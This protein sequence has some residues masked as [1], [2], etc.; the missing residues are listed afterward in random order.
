MG[1]LKKKN[2]KRHYERMQEAVNAP[3]PEPYVDP[4]SVVKEARARIMGLDPSDAMLT[5]MLVSQPGQ[6]IYAGARNADEARHLWAVFCAFDAADDAYSRR[7]IGR[8]RFPS[9]SRL[10]MMPERFETRADDRPDTRTEDEKVRDARNG[11]A[12]WEGFM[13]SLGPYFRFCVVSAARQT[14]GTL[15]VDGRLTTAGEAFVRAMRALRECSE[16]G[17]VSV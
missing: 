11:M 15:I 4:R 3:A 2:G 5:E 17:S 1:K 10:E 13:V 6:A 9:V 8:Q 7:V 12:R 14:C 16:R